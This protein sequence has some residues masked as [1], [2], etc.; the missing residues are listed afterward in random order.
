VRKIQKTLYKFGFGFALMVIMLMSCTSDPGKL[1]LDLLPND[2]LVVVGNVVDTSIQSYTA[3]DDI[4]RTD[5]S[6]FNILGAF[7]DPVFG[8]TIADFACQYRLSGFPLFNSIEEIDSLI[9]YLAYKEIYGD[10]LTTQNLKIYELLSDLPFDDKFYQNI[11][12]KGMS[13]G[14]VLSE[15]KLHPKI[16]ARFIDQQIRINQPDPERYRY[17]GNC[18][19]NEYNADQQTFSCRFTD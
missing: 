13:K 7:N 18:F 14:E 17:S 9:L 3:S 15:K 12:L 1:G 10:T 16:Q 11:D 2:D 19:C 6:S 8:K 5:E 4:Q